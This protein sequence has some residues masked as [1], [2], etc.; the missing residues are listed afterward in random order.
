ML[1]DA[2]K[3]E[4]RDCYQ[5]LKTELPNFV[6]RKEQGR[7]IADISKTLAGDHPTE[8]Q[9]FVAEAGTGIGKSLA[10]LIGAVPF[11]RTEKKK[12]V[13][14]TA[15]V[16]LQEQLLHKDLPLFQRL[17][18][19]PLEFQLAKGRQRYCCAHRLAELAEFNEE[20][21]QGVLFETKPEEK[22]IQ[23]LQA[24]HKALMAQEW[25]GDRDNWPDTISNDVWQH[26]VS[27]KHSCHAGFP[28]H[29]ECPFAK[30]RQRLTEMD[31]IIANHALLMADLELGGGVILPEIEDSI[32]VIDEAHHLPRVARDFASASAT[33]KGACAWLEK[34]NKQA[35]VWC[36]AAG[37]TETDRYQ[38]QLQSQVQTLIPTLNGIAKNL[39]P[40]YFV[41]KDC[42]RF[43]H[44]EIPEWLKE[45][46]QVLH[47]SSNKALQ[48]LT[49]IQEA[50]LTQVKSANG[51][52]GRKLES[53]STEMG[54]FIQRLENLSKVWQLMHQ[55]DPDKG[56]PLARWIEPTQ[57]KKEPDY[58]VCVAPLEVGYQLDQNLWTKSAGSVL[59]SATLRAL[60]D[61]G[62]F[63]R[64]A[65]IH[66]EDQPIAQVYA[67]PFDYPTQ[68]TL[69]L[70]NLALEPTAEGYTD[71]LIET[72]PNYLEDH[73]GSLVLFSSYWQL[74]QVAEA[75]EKHAKKHDWQW[76]VQG[77]TPRQQMLKQ[78]KAAI[79]AGKTS[80]LLG[81]SSLSE[82]LDLPGDWLTNVVITKLPFAVPT[83]PIEEAHA[84]YITA[85]GG[86]PF[87]EIA[88]PET[89]KKLIQ[90]VGRLLRS[91][92]DQGRVVILDKRVTTKRYGK[93]LIDALPPFRIESSR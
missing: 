47:V 35:S 32:Y 64:Q 50:L 8:H 15:T 10:Y 14:A 62:Y 23:Q 58:L 71:L 88:L 9:M 52:N 86:V 51:V 63:F 45:H 53:L 29:R 59:V 37:R 33:L 24:L 31:V 61:F 44:G 5:R 20:S 22:D 7:L 40:E 79:D 81:T 89:S 60:N 41:E 83:S 84:E 6:P 43:E 91:E 27:E 87:M 19:K 46:T 26:I 66:L 85:R 28:A 74:N 69:L 48:A 39:V 49:R 11:A 90:A 57:D 70:P 77:K 73:K 55:K 30:A 38:N 65:G 12:V 16:A 72:L 25:D 76:L 13:I 80:V 1:N 93:A 68:G 78:H 82:G 42:Y 92:S 36:D 4:M 34:M 3:T 56:A 18:Q 2:L 75:L 21:S 54:F 17:Y 67:S